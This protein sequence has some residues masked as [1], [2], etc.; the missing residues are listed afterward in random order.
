[1][2]KLAS[3]LFTRIPLEGNTKTRL[4]LKEE[5]G[6]LTSEEAATFYKAS[7]M[8]VIEV[9]IKVIKSFNEEKPNLENKLFIAYEPKEKE[10]NLK[11]I[12]EKSDLQG[13]SND[14]I[15]L[16]AT[17]GNNFNERIAMSFEYVFKKGYESAVMVGGDHPLISYV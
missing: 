17:S 6:I 7:M 14:S 4:T 10:E 2:K 12:L 3:I 5:G 11:R 13:L 8:D 1:M 9:F 15:E 16:F